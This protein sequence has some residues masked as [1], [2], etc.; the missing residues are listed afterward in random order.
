MMHARRSDDKTQ[1]REGRGRLVRAA[2]AG[3]ARTA[4]NGRHA[5]GSKPV[6]VGL[7]I[8]EALARTDLRG[9]VP[10]GKRPSLGCSVC[11]VGGAV[12]VL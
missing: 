10:P 12:V 2:P 3:A 5:E 11:Q 1:G 9:Q 7:R 4:V 6:A 8:G